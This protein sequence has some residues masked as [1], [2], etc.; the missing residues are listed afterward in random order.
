M[1]NPFSN[2]DVLSR[3]QTRNLLDSDLARKFMSQVYTTMAIGLAITAMAAWV[4]ANTPVLAQFFLGNTIVYYITLFA[5]LGLVI[6]LSSRINRMT[7]QQASLSFATYALV[8]GLTLSV[9]FLIYSPAIIFKVFLITAGT[10][11]A[12]ALIGATTKVDLSKFRGILMFGLVGIIIAMVVNLFMQSETFDY[13]IS[14]IGVLIFAGLTAYDT[15][16]LLQIGATADPESDAT[17]KVAIMGALTLYLDFINL[18][19]FLLR[20]FGGGRD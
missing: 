20:I 8:N 4:V 18:F 15:Q 19:L 5:P 16:K 2:G 1:Q 17:R 13:I 9:I 3:E 12:M 10:F 7:V 14:I 11:G 6:F